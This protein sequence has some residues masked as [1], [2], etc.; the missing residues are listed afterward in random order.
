MVQPP[1]SHP[2]SLGCTCL[3]AFLTDS[4]TCLR[5]RLDLEM[6]ARESGED[7]GGSTFQ[8]YVEAALH[9]ERT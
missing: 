7:V 5:R 3:L 1:N 4:L 9:N 8:C 6:A 2:L